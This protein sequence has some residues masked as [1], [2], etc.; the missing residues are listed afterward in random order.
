MG[1]KGQL[2]KEAFLSG[3]NCSQ[4]VFC[5]FA[6]DFGVEDEIARR[7]SCGLGGGVG[8][9]R[10]VC[11]AVTGAS[12]VFGLKYGDDKAQTYAKVQEFCAAFKQETG[13][14]ICRELL[15]GAKVAVENGGA[16]EPRSEQYY[17]KRPCAELVALAADIL[18]GILN[19]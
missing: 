15:E 11:G 7:I 14:I 10:E 8:R 5:A 12:L 1:S 9:M 6:G 13:S 16:P 17:R 4:A 18:E 19:K 2:A 3:C